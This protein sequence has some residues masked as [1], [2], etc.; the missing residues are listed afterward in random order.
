MVQSQQIDK[1]PGLRSG[2][3]FSMV[4]KKTLE[5]IFSK[6]I[7]DELSGLHIMMKRNS[8]Q[9]KE[10]FSIFSESANFS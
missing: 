2:C 9:N 4:T 7:F 6:E 3:L 10:M 5:K 1:I 8:E